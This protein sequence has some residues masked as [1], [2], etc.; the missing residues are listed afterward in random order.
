MIPAPVINLLQSAFPGQPIGDFAATTGG[1]SNLTAIV[2]IGGQQCVIKAAASALKRADVR[3]EATLLQLL[4][5]SELPI[6]RL[7]AQIEDDQWTV[8]VTGWLAGQ[9]GL[10]VLERTPEQLEPIYHALGA[11]LANIHRTPLTAPA[12]Q[13]ADRMRHARD[14]LPALE[15]DPQLGIVLL[16]ALEHPSWRAQ[17]HAL[18]H[19]DAGLHNLLWHGRITALLDWEWAGWGT[20][21]LD[22]AWLYWT[23]Q[24]RK[25]PPALWHSLLAGYGAG[26]ALV[27]G[28]TREELRALAL[29]QIASI[30]VR[31]HGQPSAWEEWQRRLRW[32]LALVFPVLPTSNDGDNAPATIDRARQSQ[33][34]DHQESR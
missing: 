12:P 4:R 31:S 34:T 33:H 32:T 20:P 25:L 13:L 11:L 10:A 15:F 2:A 9:H 17:P 18:A 22:L 16:E 8:A 24:W 3:R 14:H 6:P 21:L 27:N 19:G 26:P 5:T 1:F 7:L 30:L 23:I 29:G 28:A